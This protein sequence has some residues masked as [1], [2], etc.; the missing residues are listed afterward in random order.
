VL[1]RYLQRS[2]W[3]SVFAVCGLADIRV[4]VVREPP[5]RLNGFMIVVVSAQGIRNTRPHHVMGVIVEAADRTDAQ[6]VAPSYVGS[7]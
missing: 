2:S 3:C 5:Q 7:L 1:I 6:R 4:R